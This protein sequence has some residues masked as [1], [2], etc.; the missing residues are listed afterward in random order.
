VVG[1]LRGAAG[2]LVFRWDA[3]TDAGLVMSVGQLGAV[4]MVGMVGHG[5]GLRLMGHGAFRVVLND[6]GVLDVAH[7]HGRVRHHLRGTLAAH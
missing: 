3:D 6:H 1:G 2:V 4:G 7:E 5:L